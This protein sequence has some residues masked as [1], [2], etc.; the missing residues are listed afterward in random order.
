M[1][2]SFSLRDRLSS[3]M[4]HPGF[5]NGVAILSI[6][7]ATLFVAFHHQVTKGFVPEN[8]G[9]RNLHTHQI[10]RV[11]GDASYWPEG[12]PLRAFSYPLPNVIGSWLFE[13]VFGSASS[14]VWLIMV[15]AAV[16]INLLLLMRLL[17]VSRHP[18]RWLI[19]LVAVVSVKYVVEWDLRAVNCNGMY[20]ALVLGALLALKHERGWTCGLLIA[21][22]AALK[23][24]S[25]FFI[26]YFWWQ[27]Q[28]KALF[29]TLAGIAVFFVLFPVAYLG[30][31][32][33][34]NMTMS[35]LATVRGLGQGTNVLELNVYV[36]SPQFLLYHLLGDQLAPQTVAI[37]TRLI[38]FAWMGLVT[39]FLLLPRATG[40]EL[41]KSWRLAMDAA[42]LTMFPLMISP[43]F[44]PH[45]AVVTLLGA[46]L[47]ARIIFDPS[48]SWKWRVGLASVLSAVLA[49]FEVGPSGDLRGAGIAGTFLL[50]LGTMAVIKRWFPGPSEAALSVELGS[51]S[52]GS[53]GPF[54]RNA[55]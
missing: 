52:V 24:Y 13:Q 36:I 7:G 11:L 21:L 33:A 46:F 16:P 31:S 14:L 26:P 39:A 1:N 38:Q 5:V 17:D 19:A 32:D 35:W 30:W 28:W 22:S 9:D 50:L 27:R 12:E 2:H 37:L 42:A 6:L 18:Y 41:P 49:I 48:T 55:A 25:V 53:A 40:S 23:L 10:K 15:T 45:H 29:A 8:F 4:T 54:G 20:L 51:S 34:W 47:I 43:L 44:Q 3:W